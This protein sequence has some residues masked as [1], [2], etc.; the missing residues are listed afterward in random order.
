MKLIKEGLLNSI[1]EWLEDA[2]GGFTLSGVAAIII[3][4]FIHL[5]FII[6]GGFIG[7]ICIHIT[8]VFFLPP[9]T[10]WIKKKFYGD[11]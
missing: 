3:P 10:N 8:K 2:F 4:E 1:E 6:L 5:F 7:T 11:H 9:I